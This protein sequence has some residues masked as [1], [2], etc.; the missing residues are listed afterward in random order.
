MSTSK[1]E[2]FLESET[3]NLHGIK[4]YTPILLA[5]SKGYQLYN[6]RNY[7][8]VEKE[9]QWWGDSGYSTSDGLQY[10]KRNINRAIRNFGNIWIY[11]WLGT[12]DLTVKERDHKI[13]IRSTSDSSIIHLSEKFQE[14][15]RFLSGFPEVR[16][17]ILK[18]PHYSI[19]V[20]NKS[21]GHQN[22]TEY[23]DNDSI[24]WNQIDTINQEIDSINSAIGSHSPFFSLDLYRNSKYKK[25]KHRDS[26]QRH[27]YNFNFYTDG[28]HPN[29]LLSKVW[30]KRTTNQIS[31][32]CWY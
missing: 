8:T 23:K 16:Y 11:I 14:I 6:Q 30:L 13:N 7:N 32:D 1:L 4:Q 17:T 19:E 28:I 24:L 25:G 2:R 3:P 5:D 21:K 29:H 9:I 12:C 10:I 31:R 26:C 18:I 22:Y 15:G 20:Y 27:I